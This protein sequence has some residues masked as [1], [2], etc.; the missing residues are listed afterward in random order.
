[1]HWGKAWSKW[2]RPMGLLLGLAALAFVATRLWTYRA[3]IEPVLGQSRPAFVAASLAIAIVSQTLFA[4]GW[5]RLLKSTGSKVA[6]RRAFASWNI[7]LGAKYLPGKIWQAVM[8]KGMHGMPGEAVLPLYFRE[9]L[10]SIGIACLF[11]AMHAPR[12]LPPASQDVFRILVLMAG[13]ALLAA[14]MT[15]WLPQMVPARLRHWWSHGSPR[16]R[17]IAQVCLLNAAGYASLAIGLAVLLKGLSINGIGAIELASGLCFGGL[18]GLFAFFIPAGLGVREAGL[19]WF[20]S[21]ALGAGPAALIAVA[22]RAWLMATDLL[23]VAI[24]VCLSTIDRRTGA[25]KQ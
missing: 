25:L 23:V 1:M 5:V 14:S 18:A 22:S 20:L 8:R 12:A 24:G 3:Q 16:T 19:Y 7:S 2:H 6:A 11:V 13:L 9:Q 17:V 21:P 10:V 15:H 4:L